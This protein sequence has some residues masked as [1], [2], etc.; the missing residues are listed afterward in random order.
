MIDFCV[1][2]WSTFIGLNIP[3]E[4]TLVQN[5]IEIMETPVNDRYRPLEALLQCYRKQGYLDI[6]VRIYALLSLARDGD[7]IVPDYAISRVDLFFQLK[8]T[9]SI[10]ESS[11]PV[12][13]CQT[14]RSAIGL[15]LLEFMRTCC[16]ATT[17]RIE[18]IGMSIMALKS[19]RVYSVQARKFTGLA[20]TQRSA[21]C[22]KHAGNGPICHTATRIE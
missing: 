14:T 20:K 17:R 11:E 16:P 6:R 7:K 2:H 9:V 12:S 5:F 13:S 22:S 1:V 21:S 19:G 10:T 18:D 15:A 8:D 3:E 4:M